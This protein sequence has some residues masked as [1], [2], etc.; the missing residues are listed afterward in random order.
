[1]LTIRRWVCRWFGH[2]WQ[3]D[4]TG[5]TPKEGWFFEERLR[6][7]FQGVVPVMCPN[8]GQFPASI[9]WSV[10]RHESRTFRPVRPS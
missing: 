10:L 6:G 2:R 5:R 7:R 1:M 4:R 8:A 9:E 3:F